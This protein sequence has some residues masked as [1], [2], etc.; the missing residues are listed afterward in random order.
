M[1]EKAIGYLNSGFS[2]KEWDHLEKLAESDMVVWSMLEVMRV[3][4]S[5]THIESYVALNAAIG[6]FNSV[7]LEHTENK[8]IMTTPEPRASKKKPKK[9]SHAEEDFDLDEYFGDGAEGSE[10]LVGSGKI[11]S[12]QLIKIALAI[13]KL[14]IELNGMRK[15]LISQEDLDE[16]NKKDISLTDRWAN[17]RKQRQKAGEAE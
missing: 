16:A 13:P 17:E 2:K 10:F 8:S 14:N 7:I 9:R 5:K 4:F 1:N 12:D 11:T 15:A 6:Y 3:V